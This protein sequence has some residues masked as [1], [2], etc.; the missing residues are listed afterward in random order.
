MD[1]ALI[2]DLL[3]KIVKVQ[4]DIVKE[5]E[6]Y[7]SNMNKHIQALS[8]VRQEIL[9]LIDWEDYVPDAD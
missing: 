7:D 3:H 2:N 8:L 1:Y 4:G 5:K 9:Q 6:Q